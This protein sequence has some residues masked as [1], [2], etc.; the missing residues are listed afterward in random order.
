MELSPEHFQALKE[1]SQLQTAIAAAG[2][3]MKKLKEGL[4]NYKI[5]REKEALTV[6]QA[7]LLASREAIAEADKNRDVVTSLLYESL[8]VLR[9]IESLSDMLAVMTEEQEKSIKESK[10][11]VTEKVAELQ[12]EADELKKQRR[13]LEDMSANLAVRKKKV[14]EQEVILA[15]RME[16]LKQDIHRISK[17]KL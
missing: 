7:A 13:Y 3:E 6:V 4:D 9:T 12:N 15:D 17:I 2:A 10:V 8:E 11:R 14:G 16:M 5:E 1:L